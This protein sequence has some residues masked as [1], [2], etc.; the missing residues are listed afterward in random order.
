[1]AR[2]LLYRSAKIKKERGGRKMTEKNE[3]TKEFSTCCENI[4]FAEMM[5]KIMG[6]Q[7]VGSLCAEMMKKVSQKQG[8]GGSVR[9]AEMMQS[10]MKGCSGIKQESKEKKEE[11]DNVGGK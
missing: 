8:N 9:C 10:M 7:G 1:M 11:A 4:H 2:L 3:S 6:Q 5:Q